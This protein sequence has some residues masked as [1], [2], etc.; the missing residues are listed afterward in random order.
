MTP[1]VYIALCEKDPLL[2]EWQ[3]SPI[4]MWI[5]GPS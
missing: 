2:T 4:R 3:A 5:R 1:F